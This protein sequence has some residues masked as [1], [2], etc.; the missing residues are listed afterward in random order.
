MELQ[1]PLTMTLSPP[2]PSKRGPQNPPLQI[3][4]DLGTKIDFILQ[5]ILETEQKILETEQKLGRRNR[6]RRHAQLG[7]SEGDTG[8]LIHTSSGV[9]SGPGRL[10]LWH[11]SSVV[12]VRSP[13]G[14]IMHSVEV[15]IASRIGSM[16]GLVTCNQPKDSQLS[17]PEPLRK[18]LIYGRIRFVP[19]L[20]LNQARCGLQ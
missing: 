9:K 20:R 18:S 16:G 15:T 5:K 2:D 8:K 4:P 14:P 3:I 6:F 11:C 10:S 7:S 13:S 1:P 17:A 19:V 12:S